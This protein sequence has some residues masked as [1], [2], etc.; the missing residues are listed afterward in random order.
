MVYALE[1]ENHAIAH[2]DDL[3]ALR[4]ITHHQPLPHGSCHVSSIW[5]PLYQ[6]RGLVE[7]RAE[8]GF[9]VHEAALHLFTRARHERKMRHVRCV[10]GSGTNSRMER[11]CLRGA[12]IEHTLSLVM[13][14]SSGR[15][16][17]QRAVAHLRRLLRR[18][19]NV[20]L[21]N[22]LKLSNFEP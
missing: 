7:Q 11:F 12:T 21:L 10:A 6:P 18:I 19:Y 3:E 8:I 1:F 4:C 20:P 2:L 14:A 22:G 5:A 17:R 16:D 15:R 13:D 9:H